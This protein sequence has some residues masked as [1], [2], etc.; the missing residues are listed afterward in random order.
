MHILVFLVI[1]LPVIG[2]CA[3][4]AA[5]VAPGEKAKGEIIIG[6]LDDYSGPMGA[7][8]SPTREG[9]EDCIRYINEEQGGI[10][11]H[12]LRAIVIDHKM[13]SSLM[14][15]GWNRLRD[16]HAR[17]VPSVTAG[18]IPVLAEL[19]Q[20]DR[21]PVVSGLGT[22]DQ[23][24]P[25]DPSFFF[26]SVPQVPG[27]IESGF[28]VMEK[29]WNKRGSTR[30]PRIGI[31]VASLGT[32][33]IMYSKAAKMSAQK[34]GWENLTTRTSIAP[35]DVMTQVLQMKEFK[36]DYIFVGNSS[37]A[38]I[39]WVRELDRQNV[40]P[41]IMGLSAMGSEEMWSA[42]GELVVGAL[43][44][45]FSVA[46]TDTDTPLIK[47]LHEL[48][49][50]WYPEVNYRPVQYTQG[51]S[52]LSVEAEAIKRAIEKVGHENLSGDAMKEAMETIRDLDPGTGIGYT[53]TPT[54]HQGLPGVRWYAWTE[55]GTL[56]PVMGW[57][58][59]DPLPEEQRTN[60]WWMQ[61]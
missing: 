12:P 10:L 57:D 13:D 27:W 14:I 34:R 60:A 1:L 15:S 38:Q 16:E 11:G 4:K 6:L 44:M 59:F 2:A 52:N 20:K 58:V 32:M 47:F 45:Q 18:V 54:D 17:L 39:A 49:V 56:T 37:D 43:T 23:L 35:V 41:V 48:N 33:P 30:P 5:P 21:I 42:V 51:F 8:N 55:Q 31:D 40:R 28:K 7:V 3:Q 61:D 25:K 36:C 50:K 24:F 53:W 19:A 26:C 46:W 9:Y 29:D 22:L